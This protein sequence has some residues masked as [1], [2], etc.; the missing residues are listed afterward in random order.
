MLV[1]LVVVVVVGGGGRGG[2]ALAPRLGDWG[3]CSAMT[4]PSHRPRTSPPART[5][6]KETET[7][8]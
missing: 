8:E 1:A 5:P 4:S 2:D 3:A 7:G 6:G